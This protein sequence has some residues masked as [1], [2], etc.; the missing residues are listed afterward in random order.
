MKNVLAT[1]TAYKDKKAEIEMLQRELDS[2]KAELIDYIMEKTE[3]DKDGKNVYRCGQYVATVTQKTRKTVSQKELETAYPE[4][5]AT[6][7]KVTEYPE[8]RVK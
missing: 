1:L 8:L 4:I 3:T 7:T 2:M 5:A 6:M